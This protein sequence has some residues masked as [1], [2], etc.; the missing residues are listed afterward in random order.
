MGK[1]YSHSECRT[2]ADHPIFLPIRFKNLIIH[3]HSY[4]EDAASVEMPFRNQE[5][6]FTCVIK[7][8]QKPDQDIGRFTNWRTPI[9]D[10]VGGVSTTSDN[11]LS[12][13]D[14]LKR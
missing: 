1:S 4:I 9:L 13:P 2:T 6:A 5:N 10:A 14:Q 7:R 11:L 8:R 12:E 3:V